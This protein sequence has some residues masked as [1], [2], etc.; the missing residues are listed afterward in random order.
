[1]CLS[2]REGGREGSGVQ[3]QHGNE[4]EWRDDTRAR[5][6]RSR[7]ANGWKVMDGGRRDD[8]DGDGDRWGGRRSMSGRKDVMM[9]QIFSCSSDSETP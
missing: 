8:G 1:M 9:N 4:S 5:R 7:G 2:K 3:Q 6:K